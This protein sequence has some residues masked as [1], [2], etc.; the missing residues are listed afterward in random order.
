[1]SLL[2]VFHAR[3]ILWFYC[4]KDVNFEINFAFAFK[5][6]EHIC[7][8]R[9]RNIFRVSIH[10]VIETRMEFWENKKLKWAA[11]LLGIYYEYKEIEDDR[12]SKQY[13]YFMINLEI[14]KSLPFQLYYSNHLQTWQTHRLSCMCSFLRYGLL[15]NHFSFKNILPQFLPQFWNDFSYKL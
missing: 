3:R 10:A 12:P 1:M 5:E 8:Q 15:G 7:F 2:F 13:I 6:I 11:K 14:F 4:T 9:N